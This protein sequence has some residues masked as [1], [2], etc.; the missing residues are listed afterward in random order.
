MFSN[1]T[2]HCL[3]VTSVGDKC[4]CEVANQ[5][6]EAQDDAG[7]M[8]QNFWDSPAEAAPSED[9]PVRHDEGISS[10]VEAD[11]TVSRTGPACSWDDG[12][13]IDVGTRSANHLQRGVA[14][15]HRFHSLDGAA[16]AKGRV[17]CVAHHQ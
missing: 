6:Q 4:L 7:E 12:F 14:R 17:S 11:V 13:E 8:P 2:W 1:V 10:D 5:P 3:V 15:L 9:D 16:V